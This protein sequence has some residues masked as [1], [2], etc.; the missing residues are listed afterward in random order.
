MLLLKQIEVLLAERQNCAQKTEMLLK[1]V[2]VIIRQKHL[3]DV[4]HRGSQRSCAHDLQDYFPLNQFKMN[5]CKLTD[6][7]ELIP[8][9]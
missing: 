7:E 6:D 1:K 3:S 8:W 2:F 9:S 4:H 5:S